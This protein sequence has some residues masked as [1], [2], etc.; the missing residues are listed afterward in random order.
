[1][2][3][4]KTQVGSIAKRKRESLTLN[5]HT[6]NFLTLKLRYTTKVI[7]NMKCVNIYA[8]CIKDELE[9]PVSSYLNHF[10]SERQQSIQSYRQLADQNRTVWA[11]LLARYLLC[12]MIPATWAEISIERNLSGKP[13]VKTLKDE[14]Q[15]NLSHSGSW[16]ICSIGRCNNGVDVETET[17][18]FEEIARQFFLPKEFSALQIMPLSC[19]KKAFLCYWTIKESYLKYTGE[20]LTRNLSEVDCA[21]ILKGTKSI[22]GK[23]FLLPDGAVIGICTQRNCLPTHINFV[24]ISTLK[25]FLSKLDNI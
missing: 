5:E 9:M 20:G 13:Y 11:E 16:A 2:A 14:W 4:R 24:S 23:N 18:D 22:A 3:Q 25:N 7:K 19:R 17:A 1:M 6:P 15:I 12:N 8:L 21:E 10:K